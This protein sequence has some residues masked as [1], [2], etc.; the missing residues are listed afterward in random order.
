MFWTVVI[1][2]VVVVLAGAFLRDRRAKAAHGGAAPRSG[3][4]PRSGGAA[5]P[6]GKDYGFNA[7]PGPGSAGGPPAGL[8]GP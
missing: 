6:L 5:D 3:E 1:V 2:V 8:G 4:T 7:T